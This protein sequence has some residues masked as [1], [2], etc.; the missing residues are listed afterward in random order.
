M[1]RL[2][3]RQGFRPFHHRQQEAFSK[4]PKN[5]LTFTLN[6]FRAVDAQRIADDNFLN[7]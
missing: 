5:R 1:S 4:P 6:A 3:G 7:Q 2:F